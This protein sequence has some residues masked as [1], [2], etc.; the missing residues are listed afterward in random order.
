[1]VVIALGSGV[2]GGYLASRSSYTQPDAKNPALELPRTGHEPRAQGSMI[3]Y[4]SD[5]DFE[6]LRARIDDLDRQVADLRATVEAYPVSE[7]APG[8]QPDPP[9]LA[10][11]TPLGA[12]PQPTSVGDRW[13][14]EG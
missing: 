3:R 1:M 10:G 7:P 12:P 4:R 14:T 9:P 13:S 2:L 11:A 6:A 5:G 8:D